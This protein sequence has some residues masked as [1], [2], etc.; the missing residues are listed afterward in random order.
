VL[1][2][3]VDLIIRRSIR[4]RINHL[5]P[6]PPVRRRLGVQLEAHVRLGRHRRHH[7]ITH[8]LRPPALAVAQR[9]CRLQDDRG[10][11]R[12]AGACEKESMVLCE[13]KTQACL[14]MAIMT[15]ILWLLGAIFFLRSLG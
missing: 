5:G 7:E 12:T 2:K 14:R 11:G 15:G 3:S 9:G 13:L 4:N 1:G 10:E 8:A 6:V